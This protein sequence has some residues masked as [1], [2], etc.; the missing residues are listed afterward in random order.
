MSLKEMNLTV[1]FLAMQMVKL[2]ASRGK[3]FLYQEALKF[4]QGVFQAQRSGIELVEG[5]PLQEVRQR[6]DGL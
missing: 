2:K 6:G 5:T 3:K 4:H 1:I